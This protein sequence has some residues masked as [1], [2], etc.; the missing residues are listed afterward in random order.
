MD[1][2]YSDFLHIDCGVP[3]GSILGPLLFITYVNKLS[4]ASDK[5][6]FILR[7]NDT[8]IFCFHDNPTTPMEIVRN[9]LCK[10]RE[11]F[12]ANKLLLNLNKTI[13]HSNPE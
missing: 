5:L 7:A 3:Q 6:H 11:W 4:K 10:V 1:N 8:N 13:D 9:K 2:V 12:C